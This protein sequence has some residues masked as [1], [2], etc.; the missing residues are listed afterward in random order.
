MGA[1]VSLA[2]AILAAPAAYSEVAATVTDR[3]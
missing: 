3:P 2:L 1:E